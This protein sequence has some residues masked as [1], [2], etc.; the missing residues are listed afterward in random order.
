[1]SDDAAFL[2]AILADPDDDLPRLIYADY[3][4]ERGDPRGEFIRAQIEVARLPR[5][6]ARRKKLKERATQ[7]RDRHEPEW[8]GPLREF[9]DGWEFRRGFVE[10]VTL[11]ALA[12]LRQGD[13]LFAAAPVRQVALTH[14]WEEVEALA[15]CPHLARLRSL[16]LS[17]NYL[18]DGDVAVLLKSAH[19]THLDELDL[20]FNRYHAA[21]MEVLA[22]TPALGG[23]R[24]LDLSHNTIGASGA[25]A[26]ADSPHLGRLESLSLRACAVGPGGAEAIA[27]RDGLAGLTFLDLSGNDLGGRGLRAL[28]RGRGLRHLKS[29]VLY[30][31]SMTPDQRADLEFRYGDGAVLTGSRSSRL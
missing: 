1:M 18:S 24:V 6:D 5:G 9:I 11:G 8:V 3:L 30:N 16:S 27:T 12:F 23:L 4:D 14:A 21:A 7:L 20:S 13:A 19:V 31:V 29:L 2:R 15:Q 22:G 25:A 26:L 17:G 28:V 10:A